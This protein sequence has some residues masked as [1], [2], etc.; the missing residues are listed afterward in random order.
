MQCSVCQ[1][2]KDAG[3]R[4]PRGWKRFKD[5]IYCEKCWN[6][7][8]LLRAIV[9]PIASPIDVTWKELNT[10]LNEMFQLTTQASNWMVT[11]LVRRDLRR[12][13]DQTK[14]PPMPK[15]YL[16]PEARVMFPRIPSQSVASLEQ[17]VQRKYRKKRYD[18]IWKSSAALPSF[19]YPQPFPVHNQSWSPAIV[20]DRPQ[21][22]FRIAD[23][24]V[25]VRLKGGF[26]YQRQLGAFRSMCLGDALCG[27]LAF[28]RSSVDLFCK[29][30]AWLPRHETQK[31]SGCLYVRTAPDALLIAANQKDETLWRYNADQV[32][33][34][35]K[36]YEVQRQRW[37]V[38]RK[39]E[40]RPIASF[41]QRSQAA[42]Q[43]YYH[44]LQKAAEQTAA[45]LS[46]YARRR[47]FETIEFND[48]QRSYCPNFQW[49]ELRSRIEA[50]C[51]EN[52]IEFRASSE[53]P[54]GTSSP[55]AER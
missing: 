39:A 50:L 48:S 40:E 28:Y 52:G 51:E 35:T 55:L 13:P 7:R 20:E 31:K 46:G 21:V 19:R 5:Q 4:L 27:E 47:R 44:R 49:A 17:A 42:A 24:R 34:W 25:T 1:A 6:E 41:N 10:L 16:Y 30:V 29:M 38:D 53:L 43:K 23:R 18:V 32:R 11:E 12:T 26:R 37:S 2:E 54:K 36:E 9:I 15:V 45:Y 3:S 8:F 14:I 33:R 22:T